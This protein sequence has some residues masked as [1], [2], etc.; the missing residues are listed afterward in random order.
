MESVSPQMSKDEWTKAFNARNDAEKAF[1]MEAVTGEVVLDEDG[2]IVPGAVVSPDGQT[3][4]VPQITAGPSATLQGVPGTVILDHGKLVDPS[5]E[6]APA[7]V[8][9]LPPS[10]AVEEMTREELLDAITMY[11]QSGVALTERLDQ[12]AQNLYGVARERDLFVRRWNKLNGASRDPI[13]A[14]GNCKTCERITVAVRKS[15]VTATERTAEALT[16]RV[17]RAKCEGCGKLYRNFNVAGNKI[18][19]AH[20]VGEPA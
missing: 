15:D 3:I 2:K 7:P 17:R 20:T 9:P 6:E 12:M 18:N 10:K 11:R 19:V 16:L 4:T 8:F 1:I 13:V 5:P 14:Y